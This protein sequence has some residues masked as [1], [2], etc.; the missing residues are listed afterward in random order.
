MVG[1]YFVVKACATD[2]QEAGCLSFIASCFL[3]GLYDFILLCFFQRGFSEESLSKLYSFVAPPDIAAHYFLNTID[4]TMPYIPIVLLAALF[5]YIQGKLTMSPNSGNISQQMKMLVWIGPILTL[6]LLWVWPAAVGVYWIT[7]TLFS[8]V[9]QKFIM[10]SLKH[11][12]QVSTTTK[13]S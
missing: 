9:Q 5:Q 12:E 11:D 8:I 6:V 1:L 3:K 7:T 2:F 4:L 10:K 13:T